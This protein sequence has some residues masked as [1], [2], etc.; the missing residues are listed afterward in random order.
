MCFLNQSIYA[1]EIGGIEFEA[2]ILED[3]TYEVWV[4]PLQNGKKYKGKVIIP[5]TINILDRLLKVTKIDFEAF[6]DCTEL[7]SVVM[8]NTIKCIESGAFFACTGLTTITIPNSVTNIGNYAFSYCESLTS[9]TIPSSVTV[10]GSGA[11]EGSTGFIEIISLIK[12]PFA[13]SYCWDYYLNRDI[14]LYVPKGT[15]EL[16]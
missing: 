6:S 13:I 11:F 12:E 7:T 16:Y 3:G 1:E 10:I 15:K 14:P 8:P 9:I 5:E 2:V 4:C